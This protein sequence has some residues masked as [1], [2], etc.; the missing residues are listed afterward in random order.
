MNRM[1][2]AGVYQ[3]MGEHGSAARDI[4][5]LRDRAPSSYT[6]ALAMRYADVVASEG[7]GARVLDL[8]DMPEF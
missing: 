8:A 6:R 1:T 7:F 5:I 2:R 4:E 3:D